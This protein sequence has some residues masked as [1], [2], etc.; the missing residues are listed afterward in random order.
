MLSISA[1]S[2]ALGIGLPTNDCSTCLCPTWLKTQLKAFAFLTFFLHSSIAT[3][4]NNLNPSTLLEE[5]LDQLG[6]F[7]VKLSTKDLVHLS[8]ISPK[9]LCA[10]KRLENSFKS[11]LWK[12]VEQ[13]MFI[14]RNEKVSS[15]LVGFLLSL[16]DH[17]TAASGNNGRKAKGSN[18]SSFF[19]SKE[20]HVGLSP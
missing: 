19:R 15:S 14:T 6:K 13:L 18:A 1:C 11:D 3:G 2:R 10:L 5:A 20:M 16:K 17:V 7:G 8:L 12:A 9:I 4:K